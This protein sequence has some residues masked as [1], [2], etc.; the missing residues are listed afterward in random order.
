MILI[1]RPKAQLKNIKSKL[2]KQGYAVFHESFYSLYYYKKKISYDNNYYYIFPSIHSAK[3]LKKNKQIYKFKN[4]NILVI[5]NQV[6]K[7]LKEFGCKNFVATVSDGKSLL[8]TINSSNYKNKNFIYLCSNV[9]NEDLFVQARKNRIKINKK[10]VYKTKRIKVVSKKLIEN[11]K[12]KKIT[13]AIFYSKFSTQIFL[14]IL[15]KY[16]IKSSVETIN[17]Y[18]ISDRVAE[19]FIKNKFKNVYVSKRPNEKSLITTIKKRH[20]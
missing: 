8:R 15:L 1:T 3:S 18:C 7:I 11:F 4:A 10:I 19:L 17:M 12:L 6:K 9:T 20:F 13:A 5:G 16:K 2:T 14:D